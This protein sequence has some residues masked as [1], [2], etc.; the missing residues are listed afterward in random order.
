MR[1]PVASSQPPRD[2]QEPTPPAP[3]A[4]GFKSPKTSDASLE[5]SPAYKELSDVIKRTAPEVVRQVVRD[6]WDKCLLGSEYHLAFLANATFHQASSGTL[7]R[8]LKDFGGNMVR[9]GKDSVVAHFTTE[10]LDAVSDAILAKASHRFLD[11][12]LARRL[13]TIRA[14]PLVNALA[15]AE[16]LGYDVRDIVEETNGGEHVLPSLHLVPNPPAPP[17]PVPS[18]QLP[19]RPG[20]VA[21]AH[22]PPVSREPSVASI[23]STRN[24]GSPLPAGPAGHLG[25]VHCSRCH[26]P[27]SGEKAFQ[28]HSNKR[29][30]VN[31]WRV[32]DI[33]TE[34]CPH[35]GCLFGSS[36]GLNY[37]IKMK[38]CGEYSDAVKEAVLAEL[39]SKKFLPVGHGTGPP[40]GTPAPAPTP[41]A[42]RAPAS[43]PALS[44]DIRHANMGHTPGHLAALAREGRSPATWTPPSRGAVSSPVDDPYAKLTP[45]QRRDFEY[46][47]R[48]AEEKYGGL[49][50]EAMKLPE[51]E[52]EKEL[53]KLKNS[54]NTK[55]STTR[56][57]YGIR[58]R[59]RRSVA[60]VE[61]ERT[62]LLG[63]A[64]D[65]AWPASTP[66]KRPYPDDEGPATAHQGHE[67]Q[68]GGSTPRRKR[69]P[70]NEMGGGLAS[71]AATAEHTDPTAYLTASQPRFPAMSQTQRPQL[72]GS[73][74]KGTPDDPMEID[75]DESSESDSDSD[76][77]DI[78]AH[79]AGR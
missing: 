70:V 59:Q 17:K 29:A 52:R 78:P 28:H 77:G 20:P 15:R 49:M 68:S 75:D 34:I 76:D 26:R 69:V 60:E 53:A 13:E 58:L 19:S 18:Q 54:Y 43:T 22:R 23:G 21:A 61:A 72:H 41:P 35:C 14:R 44:S 6:S 42:P 33:G 71:A 51:A 39:R 66:S 27:C 25:I 16:R 55:Q 3:K 30:C 1:Q 67:P 73:G 46:D 50:M 9:T 4:P 2:P 45:E 32:D 57:K 48:Q 63:P 24:S 56:K 8:A 65:V 7:A 5:A 36:G 47:M 74:A 10:D 12:A 79:P 11:K 40:T 64:K 37:H 31:T 38:V 62:R